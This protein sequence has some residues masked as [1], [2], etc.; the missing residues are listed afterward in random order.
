MGRKP[1]GILR[2]GLPDHGPELR[3]FDAGVGVDRLPGQPELSGPGSAGAADAGLWRVDLGD[4][5]R[6]GESGEPRRRQSGR[7]RPQRLRLAF[8]PL[9]L[10]QR[11]ALASAE[12]GYARPGVM[13]GA[14]YVGTLGVLGLVTLVALHG[15]TPT[16]FVQGTGGTP[17]RQ[18][19]LGSAIAMF[20]FTAGLLSGASRRPL[21]AFLYWYTLAL[22]LIAVGLLGIM[23][24]SVLREL[25][26]LDGSCGSVPQRRVYAHCGD[27]LRARV[28]CLAYSAL[29]TALR[30]SEE[31]YRDLVQNANSII[32][33]WDM[34]GNFTFFNEFADKFF[35]FSQ[36]EII[37]KNVMGT[38][39]PHTDTAGRDLAAMIEDIKRH[40]DRYGTNVNENVR[41]NGDRVWISWSNRA[42]H[43]ERGNMIG[44]LA[45]G[46][47]ITAQRRAEEGLARLA[48]IV[49][50]FD[51]AIL[52]KDLNGIIQ[53]W[54]AGAE[55]LFGYRAEE[56]IGQPI[57]LLLPPERIQEEEQILDRLLGGQRVEHLE[58]V[59]VAK[60]GGRIDVS[61]TVSPLKGED[62][63]I[64]GA[65]K[66]I[67]D[68]T[69][70][71][72]AEEALTRERKL[73]RTLIDNLPD[74]VY[75]KDTQSR[76]L[77]ANL[78]SGAVDGRCDGQRC[79]G[80][81]RC[82]LL[83]AGKCGRVSCRRG[84]TVAIR[85]TVG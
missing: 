73:F 48:A 16:F 42:I 79:P 14:A 61:V 30:E 40:P 65:A 84:G 28:R 81:V 52:S 38:I 5:R 34:D 66:I 60:N 80:K 33:R 71:K 18:F 46:N 69:D 64:I 27:C 32:I 15:Y 10:Y 68:I 37:G 56:V 50:S 59:R 75:V 4:C 21:S 26:E 31:K 43:D 57:T 20:L 44:V 36:S 25:A 74:C 9:S 39:V 53:T 67:H 82:R 11:L 51:D 6:C 23:I 83:P 85:A 41:K 8:V 70:R 47:D 1:A 76:F 2:V 35:G 7:D 49:E 78:A 45:V 24:E 3:L 62:G 22:G 55:R 29:E 58:T 17:V 19:V 13:P 72:R 77:A 54:N 12:A 63:R